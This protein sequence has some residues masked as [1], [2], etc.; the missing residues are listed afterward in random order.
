MGPVGSR[1]PLGPPPGEGPPPQ[2]RSHTRALVI[3][4]FL[5]AALCGMIAWSQWYAIHVNVPKYQALH[6]HAA[7]H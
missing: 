6:S 4:L 3:V 5:I 2:P 1:Q 7:A